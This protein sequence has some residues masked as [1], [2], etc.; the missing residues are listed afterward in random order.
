MQVKG[1]IA[2]DWPTMKTIKIR[3]HHLLC[4]L[5]Y[6]GEGYSKEFVLNFNCITNKLNKGAFIEIV[7]MP[8]DICRGLDLAQP[9]KFNERCREVVVRKKDRQALKSLNTIIF[10]ET[11]LVQGSLIRPD[12]SL[13]M[14]MRVNYAAGTIRAACKDCDW[15]RLCTEIAR[16]GYPSVAFRPN[17]APKYNKLN[18]SQLADAGQGSLVSALASTLQIR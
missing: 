8:D 18:G 10:W 14:R 4:L 11:P 17:I 9:H 12:S 16:R 3:P 13:V 7:M 15:N 6:R 1:R 5:A 2:T